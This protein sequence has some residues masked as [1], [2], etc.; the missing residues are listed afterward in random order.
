MEPLPK[1]H[2]IG[3]IWRLKYWIRNIDIYMG[4][5]YYEF[6]RTTIELPDEILKR[7]KIKAV[8][9]GISLKQLFTR[10]LEKELDHKSEKKKIT[11]SKSNLDNSFRRS[12]KNGNTG[13]LKASKSGFST[14][15]LK[16]P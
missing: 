5:C 11:P 14:F 1:I 7:A 15:K 9:E 2:K 3:A 13:N 16:N 10:A 4:I 12:L 6:M 8:Q